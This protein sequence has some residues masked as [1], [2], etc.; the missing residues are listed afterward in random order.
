[1]QIQFYGYN[2]ELYANASEA[3]HKSQ[4]LVAIAVMVQVHLLYNNSLFYLLFLWKCFCF[5]CVFGAH[6]N[7]FLVQI[8]IITY[9]DW[10]HSEYG[11]S[12][13]IVSLQSSYLSRF[14]N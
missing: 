6:L 12:F 9:A 13:A 10:R 4:G 14:V 2:A 3:R 7:V 8:I 11:T 1:M 5:M